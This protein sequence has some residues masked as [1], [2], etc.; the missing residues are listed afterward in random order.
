MVR[1]IPFRTI[2]WLTVT[3]ST[4]PGNCV[5]K[6]LALTEMRSVLSSLVRRFNINFAP[7][8][9]PK[10]WEKTLR[11]QYILMRGKLPVVITER[12]G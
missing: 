4:G 5:G 3:L 7:G 10:D 8:Y 9:E 1:Y 11:D 12:T 6:N 2:H